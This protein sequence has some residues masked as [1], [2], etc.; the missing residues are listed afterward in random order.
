MAKQ[1]RSI[2]YELQYSLM[3]SHRNLPTLITDYSIPVDLP[4]AEVQKIKNL[5]RFWERD[6]EKWMAEGWPKPEAHPVKTHKWN[7]HPELFDDI[8]EENESK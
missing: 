6:F 2:T 1:K 5:I 4:P 3:P 7:T 8:V